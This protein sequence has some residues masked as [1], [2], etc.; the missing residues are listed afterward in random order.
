MWSHL[1]L[2]KITLGEL[3]GWIK[4]GK[5]WRRKNQVRI[6]VIQREIVEIWTKA[7]AMDTERRRRENIKTVLKWTPDWLIDW[8]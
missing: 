8:I 5:D 2:K 7:V 4:K 1:Q 6:V 3:G